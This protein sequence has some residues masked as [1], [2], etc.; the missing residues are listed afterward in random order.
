M[1]MH[2]VSLCGILLL[3]APLM[4]AQEHE[5]QLSRVERT[6]QWDKIAALAGE[7][8]GYALEGGQKSP[9]RISMRMT[10]DGSAMM[11]WMDAGGSHEMITMFHMDKSDLLATHYCAAHN[12]PR[13]R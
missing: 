9:A 5:G 1:N 6:P 12:Q 4:P 2:V 7:W 3:Y 11:H 13:L 8:E 10:G